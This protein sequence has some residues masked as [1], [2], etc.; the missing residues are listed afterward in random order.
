MSKDHSPSLAPRVLFITPQP[1]FAERGSPFRVRATVHALHDLGF[2]VDLLSLPLGQDVSTPGV[3]LHRST[4][5]LGVSQ[6]PIGPS[7]SKALLD[8]FLASRALGLA[9]SNSYAFFHG[10]E[11]AAL[12]CQTLGRLFRRPWIMDMHS[13]M[14]QQI[15]EMRFWGSKSL[16]ALVRQCERSCLLH[17]DGIMT[18]SDDITSYAAQFASP[19]VTPLTL[20]DLPL[21]ERVVTDKEQHEFRARYGL[22]DSAVIVYTGNLKA[23]QGVPLLVEAFSELRQHSTDQRTYKL[24]IVGGGPD[25]QR[26]RATLESQARSLAV[27]DDVIFTG[28]RPAEEMPVFFA[29]ADVF[30]S[31]RMSGTNTPLK[32][33]SYLQATKPLVATRILSH[34]YALNDEVAFLAAPEA[35]Q[36]A[37]ALRTALSSEAEDVAQQGQRAQAGRA[38]V[39]SRFSRTIFLQRLSEL[40]RGAEQRFMETHRVKSSTSPLLLPATMRARSRSA[41]EGLDMPVADRSESHLS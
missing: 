34:T 31:P 20:F 7:V 18:V 4:N 32:I 5:V 38:L 23:Y 39:E 10:V 17:A 1:F 3:H 35:H 22:H 27:A 26:E 12:I 16:S 29:L 6:L 36:F 37:S 11:E 33:Y 9:R 30:A 21:P 19:Q 24:L 41:E 8:V 14:P 2:E 13:C 28:S 25:E 40:Y 15:A